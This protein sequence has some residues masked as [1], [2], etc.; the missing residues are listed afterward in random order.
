M[1]RSRWPVRLTVIALAT[2]VLPAA[3]GCGKQPPQIPQ[4]PPPVQTTN[5]PFISPP[6]SPTPSAPPT[7]TKTITDL[8]LLNGESGRVYEGVTFKSTRA[9]QTATITLKDAHDIVFRDCVV[10]G[11]AWNAITINDVDHSVYNIRFE[12]VYVKRTGR[13]GFECTARGSTGYAN[14]VLDHVTIEPSG[15]EAISFDGP[16]HT[17]RILDTT[18]MGSGTNR[19][20]PGQGFEINGSAGFTVDGLTI[21]QTRG[22]A[23][24]L[25]GPIGRSS[26]WTFDHVVAD[27]TVHNQSVR[28]EHTSQVLYA[29]NMRGAKWADTYIRAARPGGGVA[30]LDSCSR[31]DFRG[32]RWYDARGG[33]WAQPTLVGES[34]G[35]LFAAQA[36]PRPAVARL[37]ASALSD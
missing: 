11:S 31:N 9:F 18:I 27:M 1:S 33:Q 12:N 35:N 10:E 25:N 15:S 28:Q 36:A 2:A 24:N 29:H 7:A 5:P 3:A 22:S 13:M 6:P 8:A 17:C 20:Y 23:F 26:H 16:G 32:V 19:D 21:F 34:F 14:I 37:S 4:S 30:Y